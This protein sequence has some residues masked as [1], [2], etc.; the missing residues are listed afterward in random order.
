MSRGNLSSRQVRL[1]RAWLFLLVACVLA[2]AGKAAAEWR[3]RHLKARAAQIDADI[4]QRRDTLWSQFKAAQRGMLERTHQPDQALALIEVKPTS[5]KIETVAQ[6]P[7]RVV[8]YELPDLN[9]SLRFEF[10][11]DIQQNGWGSNGR[12]RNAPKTV[13][14]RLAMEDWSVRAA[15]PLTFAGVPVWLGLLLWGVFDPTRRP[16]L[17]FAITAW[18]CFCTVVFLWA[19]HYSLTLQGTSANDRLNWGAGML[20]ISLLVAW[21]WHKSLKRD[22]LAC[23]ECDYHLAG[24]TSGVC[25]ECGTAIDA[26]TRERVAAAATV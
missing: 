22:P 21:R 10:S 20:A 12:K 8:A 3:M 13:A 7:R 25:P 4:E 23:R 19:P 17:G 11:T 6:G 5:D 16:W 26:I 15:R 14:K 24:N 9:M 1:R 2:V 18:A